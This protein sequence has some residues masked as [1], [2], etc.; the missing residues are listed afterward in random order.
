M[1]FRNSGRPRPDHAVSRQDRRREPALSAG[2]EHDRGDHGR[3]R[4]PP[5]RRPRGRGAVG[6]TRRAAGRADRPGQAARRRDQEP[7]GGKGGAGAA[8]RLRAAV[9]VAYVPRTGPGAEARGRRAHRHRTVHA[10]LCGGGRGK[11]QGR[12]LGADH[13]RPLPRRAGDG[14]PA[15]ARFDGDAD[16]AL[17]Q[18]P[19]VPRASMPSSPS[20]AMRSGRC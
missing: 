3:D 19:D 1:Q 15:E 5:C 2:Y 6:L 14:G 13:A 7:D 10:A 16:D 8:R 18:Q 11:A 17:R 20:A 12:P 9:R 4:L